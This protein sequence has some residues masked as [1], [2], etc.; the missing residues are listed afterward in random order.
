METTNA[1]DAS[2]QPYIDV[3]CEGSERS[4]SE[5]LDLARSGRRSGGSR[6]P[7]RGRGRGAA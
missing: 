2:T 5:F 4:M 6:R 7:A 1:L 3:L